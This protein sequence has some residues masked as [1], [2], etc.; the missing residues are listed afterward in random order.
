MKTNLL[1]WTL[2]ISFHYGFSQEIKIATELGLGFSKVHTTYNSSIVSESQATLI[3]NTKFLAGMKIGIMAQYAIK[4]KVSIQSGL[5]YI[6]KGYR[7]NLDKIQEYMRNSG[8]TDYT[9]KGKWET[10]YNY[11]EI[12]FNAVY[13]Y[14]DFQV[15]GGPYLSIATGGKEIVDIDVSSGGASL[16]YDK[17]IDIKPVS[18][19]VTEEDWVDEDIL[20]IKVYNSIDYGLNL[21]IGYTYDKFLLRFQYS[22]GMK[23]T[24]PGIKDSTDFDPDEDYNLKNR[25]LSFSIAYF[26]K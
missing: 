9:I 4:D 15:Y 1:L 10:H 12:P 11:L 23:N 21:G 5:Y 26:L 17:S 3:D 2:L 13:H 24:I 6:Q 7:K 22:L 16:T 8:S 25:T 18:G 20:A 14:L 19:D